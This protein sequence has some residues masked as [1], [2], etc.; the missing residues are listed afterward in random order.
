M[1][2]CPGGNCT[3][4][5]FTSF[6]LC[7]NCRDI[8]TFIQSNTDCQMH[9]PIS[10][11]DWFEPYTICNYTM[12]PMENEEVEVT[13][14]SFPSGS[15][16]DMTYHVDNQNFTVSF[17]NATT[18][19]IGPIF[20]IFSMFEGQVPS[21]ENLNDDS[22]T[23]GTSSYQT[24]FDLGNGTSIPP[25]VSLLAFLKITPSTGAVQDTHLCALSFCARRF[26][27]SVI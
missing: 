19:V 3:W 15:Y 9:E 11:N 22:L 23:K 18:P 2:Q 27:S 14:V 1:F 25:K 12:P 5:T 6:G 13:E 4:S 20:S 26:N 7:S 17:Y 21:T 24:S 10:S 8:T 16:E